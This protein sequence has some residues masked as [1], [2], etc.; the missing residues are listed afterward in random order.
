MNQQAER[1]LN[2]QLEELHGQNVHEHI[3]HHRADG[4]F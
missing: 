3:H 1:I 4:A 2:W